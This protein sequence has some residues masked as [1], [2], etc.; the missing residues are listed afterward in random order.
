MNKKT[1][2]SQAIEMWPTLDSTTA[3]EKKPYVDNKLEDMM[4]GTIK[5]EKK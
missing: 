4:F 5:K 3:Q 1:K 2:N